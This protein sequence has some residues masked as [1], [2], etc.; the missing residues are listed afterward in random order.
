MPDAPL[1]GKWELTDWFCNEDINH[2]LVTA[3]LSSEWNGLRPATIHMEYSATGFGGYKRKLMIVELP[4]MLPS[5]TQDCEF[6]F[7]GVKAP[8]SSLYFYSWRKDGYLQTNETRFGTPCGEGWDCYESPR[9]S[10]GARRHANS[11]HRNR[12]VD[13]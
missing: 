5:R 9:T 7:S 2:V 6:D 3:S 13:I 4:E 11:P 1:G 12:N 8:F 10:H